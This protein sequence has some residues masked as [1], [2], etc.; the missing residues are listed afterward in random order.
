[1]VRSSWPTG[2]APPRS[3]AIPGANAIIIAAPADDQRRITE[4]IRQLDIPQQQV[5]VEA[6]IVE[7]SNNVAREL[8]VQLLFGGENKPFTVTNF[9]NSS[10]NIIDIAGGLAGRQFRSDDDADQRR[11]RDHLDQQRNWRS[12][13]ENAAIQGSWRRAGPI[14][15]S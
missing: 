4:L 15:G 12:A 5:L 1:M 13:A 9:S 6:I 2:A 11:Y 10:P 7:I 8:G 14:P 3:P